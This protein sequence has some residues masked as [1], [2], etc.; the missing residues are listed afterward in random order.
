MFTR[1]TA[2]KVFPRQQNGRA[3]VFREVQNKFWIRH[4]AFIIQETPVVE[5]VC[6][7]TGAGHFL[8]KLLRN[9][10]VSIDVSGIQGDNPACVLGKFL[11][12]DCLL[13]SGCECRRNGR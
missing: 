13:I 8:Q 10:G 11:C 12:H 7:K 6:T 3:C 9:D 5:Q 1:R 4:F 2:A